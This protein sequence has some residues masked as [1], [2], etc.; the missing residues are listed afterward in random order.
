M[1]EELDTILIKVGC[2]KCNY[3]WFPRAKGRTFKCPNCQSKKWDEKKVKVTVR[4]ALSD[5]E[6]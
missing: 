6:D 2:E 4:E 5:V 1:T 3:R